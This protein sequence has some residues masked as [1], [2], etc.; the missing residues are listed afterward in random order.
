MKKHIFLSLIVA[1]TITAASPCFAQTTD[2]TS[3]TT[4]SAWL[5]CEIL[6]L[7]APILNQRER[8]RQVELPSIAENTTS[9]VDQTAGPDLVGLG[10]NFVGLNSKGEDTNSVSPAMTTSAYAIYAMA[11][12]H[13]PLDPAF[14]ARHANLR[15]FYFT[16]GS[17]DSEEETNGKALLFGTKVLILNNRDASN[18]RNRTALNS[19]KDKL[20][21]LAVGTANISQQVQD[22]LLAQLGP[23]V[24]VTRASTPEE[25]VKFFN[26]TL[27]GPALQTTLANLTSSQVEDI[28]AIIARGIDS[29]V[30]FAE[31][32]HRVFSQIRRAPQLSF[33]FQTKQRSEMHDDEYRAGLLFDYGV[34][35]RINLTVNGTFDYRNSPLL[36]GDTR[37]GRLAMESNFQLNPERTIAGSNSPI[38][39]STSGEAKWLSGS[40]PNY[41]GQLKL[42]IPLFDGISLP[43][44]L[45]VANRSEL[46]Q[47]K[48]VKGRFGFTFDL[49]KL[50]MRP[51]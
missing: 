1:L 36:G 44:S 50:M 10:M 32:V 17:D 13:D 34:V 47:E 9:L 48:T 43:I 19:V 35:D 25:K 24:G 3:K 39:F 45:S 51:K 22:Y 14:Y 29:R 8:S 40:K 38:M 28:R 46:I 31:E 20:A 23:A 26:D 12:Q 4:Y 18:P 15:R 21:T 42:T 2:C 30:G 49:T 27:N 33:T 37:G 11:V 5:D 6:N 41:T 7:A 16:F